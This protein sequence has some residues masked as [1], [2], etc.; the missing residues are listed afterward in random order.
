MLGRSIV[1]LNRRNGKF[2][3]KKRRVTVL[4]SSIDLSLR[5]YMSCEKKLYASTA[6]LLPVWLSDSKRKERNIAFW[7]NQLIL[8]A[9]V[10]PQSRCWPAGWRR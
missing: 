5:I 4:S 2:E 6:D 8:A 7:L 9:G 1:S 3:E 10:S